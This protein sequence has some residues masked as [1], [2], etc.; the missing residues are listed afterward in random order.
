[1]TAGR[2][3][4]DG[5][6][7]AARQLETHANAIARRRPPRGAQPTDIGSAAMISAITA[8]A[9]KVNAILAARINATTVKLTGTGRN[10]APADD[11]ATGTDER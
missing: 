11:A 4:A 7:M 5:L 9:R 10:R 6:A 2:I 8:Q 3:W 1:M